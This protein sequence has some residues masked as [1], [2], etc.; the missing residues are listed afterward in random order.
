MLNK[1]IIKK[2]INDWIDK[3]NIRPLADKLYHTLYRENITSKFPVIFF[4]KNWLKKSDVPLALF[5]GFN[6]WKRDI[7]SR[8]FPE[9]KCAFVLNHTKWERI[10]QELL[11]KLEGSEK[12]VFVTWGSGKLPKDVQK[13][14]KRQKLFEVEFRSVEDGFLRSIGTGLLHT[15]PMSVCID[16]LSIYFNAHE[17]SH[18]E[19]IL[20][21]YDFQNDT[22]LLKRAENAIKLIKAGRLTKYYDVSPNDKVNT[23]SRTSNYSILIVGQVEGDASIA[24]GK[25]S[26]KLNTELVLTA[27]KEY[28]NADIYFKPHPDYL[29]QNRKEKS[30]INALE[31]K[32]VILPS[33]VKLNEVIDKVDHVF[34]ITSLVGFEALIRGKKVTTFGAPF[35][36]N[37]GLTDDRVKI[38]RRNRNLSL[39]ELV[40]GAYIL[41]PK[42]FHP[43][44]DLESSFEEIASFTLVEI[45]KYEN[46]FQFNEDSIYHDIRPL[47]SKLSIPLQIIKYLS[48]TKNQTE[49]NS[50]E[51]FKII[52]TNFQLKDFAQISFLLIKTSNF[53]QLVEYTN[54]CLSYLRDN[55][56]NINS[57]LLYDFLYNLSI[58]LKNTNGRVINDIPCL[59]EY[60]S[61]NLYKDSKLVGSVTLYIECCAMNLHYRNIERLL[62]GLRKEYRITP[63]P[64]HEGIQRYIE[65][66]LVFEPSL[67]FYE[68]LLNVVNAKSSRSERDYQSRFRII[69]KLSHLFEQELFNKYPDDH[70]LNG[71]LVLLKN[72]KID[73]AERLLTKELQY[74]NDANIK[75]YL[76]LKRRFN[77]W[78]Y[79]ANTFI[80]FHKIKAIE[81]VVKELL[82]IEDSEK[83]ALLDLNFSKANNEDGNF[84]A[85]LAMYS[86][87]FQDSDKILTLKA[88]YLREQ[89][90]FEQAFSLYQ[91][92]HLSANTIA[93]KINL[94]QEIDKVKFSI[95]TSEIINSIPQPCIPKGVVFIA[96]QTCFN[97]LAMI[98]PSLV[99]L[100]KKGYAVVNLIQGVTNLGLVGTPYIDKFNGIIP[101]DLTVAKT[102][103]ELENIWHVNWDKKEVISEGVNYYQG[104]YER[105]STFIRKFH[106]D[107]KEPYVYDLF[108]EQLLRADICLTVCKKIF[109]EAVTNN[110]VNVTFMTSNSH[111]TPYSIMRD[112]AMAKKSDNMGFINCNVAYESYFSNLASKF[113]NTMCVSDMTL[114]PTIRAPF[115]ARREQFEA[116]YD[117][118][119]MNTTFK[120]QASSLIKVNRVGSDDNKT[121]AEL[122]EKIKEKKQQGVKIICAFGKVPVDLNVPF[123][124]GPAHSDMADWISHT[125]DICNG[126][127]E[128]LLLV[129]PHPHELRP[130]IALDLVEG[131]HDL[132]SPEVQNNVWLLGHK[133]IN[134]HALA[135]YLDLALLYNGSTSL[136]LTAQGIPVL[137]ASYF[138]RYDYPVDLIYP[139]SREN[140]E[141]FIKSKQYK[142]PEQVTREKAAYLM[143]YM[144]TDEISILN[145]YS[146]RQ[147]TNDRVGIPS[148]Y[149]E[150]IEK[151]VFEGD[152]LMALVAD[153]VVEKFE[154]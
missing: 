54:K 45:L 61:S 118:N 92:V 41:Y 123:D 16:P 139:E 136:E 99:E 75:H 72:K 140:Y 37:W 127:D 81:P 80:K 52:D 15:R 9:Y 43:S 154:S 149:P 113:S 95:D 19:K 142:A 129:K 101:L 55:V 51:L 93:R 44:C 98:T 8:F 97:S 108:L 4:G 138:G 6:S 11:L 84:D 20:N 46:I 56:V 143:C 76:S 100:K 134:G 74:S 91:T 7:F 25:S 88:R 105:L 38:K 48:S 31:K 124:G 78:L 22:N 109:S 36:S 122:L 53:D 2:K 68:K 47:I 112:Y 35:Y 18:L 150:K 146:K 102:V 42:Y 28:P 21:E 103:G 71:L 90:K 111:V 12:L 107:L 152:P 89:G 145:Q 26:V 29:A 104:F 128:I 67:V 130:E 148:W 132:I 114:Y 83:I 1:K 14:L 96:S 125:V 135:P 153:R 70:C 39:S 79:V 133:D 85:K 110:Q 126:D 3:S 131:F 40:A 119:K 62:E 121:E 10:E 66:S 120:K 141:Q 32:C 87:I 116:W 65:R 94:Q 63:F 137:M 147:L 144:G 69:Q 151:L 17:E 57:Q 115:M 86:E 117:K 73:E 82:T 34:T 13:W 23:F 24:F 59:S 77:N 58:T 27:C 5:F 30:N 60:F 49:A 64:L 50:I 33:N 106:V